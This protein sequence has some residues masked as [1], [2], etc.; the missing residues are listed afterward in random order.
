MFLGNKTVDKLER[1]FQEV[2]ATRRGGE[3][4]Q[5]IKWEISEGRKAKIGRFFFCPSLGESSVPKSTGL[6][7][8]YRVWFSV[9]SMVC[10][11]NGQTPYR[12]L[13]TSEWL[14]RETGLIIEHLDE[15]ISSKVVRLYAPGEVPSYPNRPDQL[16]D[17]SLAKELEQWPI[18]PDIATLAGVRELIDN[19]PPS[20]YRR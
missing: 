14:G 13:A 12:L 1:L 17:A 18:V 16:V 20:D 5:E 15:P 10:I 8:I 7:E 9:P 11:Q 4:Y 3:Y 2:P 6:T 19:C